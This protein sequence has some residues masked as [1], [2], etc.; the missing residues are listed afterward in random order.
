M[1]ATCNLRTPHLSTVHDLPCMFPWWLFHQIDI[2][3]DL[4]KVIDTVLNEFVLILYLIW[5][6]LTVVHLII[7][8]TFET[9]CILMLS[10]FLSLSPSDLHV[11][12]HGVYIGCFPWNRLFW[13]WRLLQCILF[14][15]LIRNHMVSKFL[16]S[17]K[18]GFCS[19]W[20]FLLHYN[21]I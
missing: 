18:Q 10:L 20:F 12:M 3:R 7:W 13:C 17:T 8:Y 21:C 4:L 16:L 5:H 1:L 19:L 2:N 9:V 11:G 15:L 14:I 6:F